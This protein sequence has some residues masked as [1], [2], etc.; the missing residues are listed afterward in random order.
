MFYPNGDVAIQFGYKSK[1]SL[2]LIPL[3]DLNMQKNYA[4][5]L[6]TFFEN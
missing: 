3:K 4:E 1:S 2:V 6:N 5:K